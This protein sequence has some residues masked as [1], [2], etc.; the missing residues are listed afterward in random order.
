M[1]KRLTT[2]EHEW[3]P[4]KAER[5]TD[6]T[7]TTNIV[8]RLC[9]TL[10]YSNTGMSETIRVRSRLRRDERMTWNEDWGAVAVATMF[11]S[12]AVA[13]RPLQRRPRR[14]NLLFHHE[15]HEAHGE[16]LNQEIRSQTRR[17]ENRG[18]GVFETEGKSALRA[19]SESGDERVS[20]EEMGFPR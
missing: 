1:R 15:E 16:L 3:T 18:N 4:I 10:T 12:L 11:K 8:G 17:G 5:T 14:N 19:P 6:Y 7:A 2:N 20:I 13:S 9:Q